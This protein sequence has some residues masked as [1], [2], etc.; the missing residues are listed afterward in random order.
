MLA[1]VHPVRGRPGASRVEI[2]AIQRGPFHQ[3]QVAWA[4]DMPTWIDEVLA[5][6]APLAPIP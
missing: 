2:H 5:D 1:V 6:R 3:G 4:R